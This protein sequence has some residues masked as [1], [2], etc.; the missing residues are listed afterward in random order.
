MK[1]KRSYLQPKLPTVFCDKDHI[2]HSW[3]QRKAMCGRKPSHLFESSLLY[4]VLSYDIHQLMCQKSLYNTQ[5][6]SIAWQNIEILEYGGP[7]QSALFLLDP[8]TLKTGFCKQ[9]AV[10]MCKE[11]GD[12]VYLYIV[13]A[14]FAHG[15]MTGLWHHECGEVVYF[16]NIL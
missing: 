15:I 3:N 16:F 14:W 8:P 7:Y 10:F 12:I 9:R 1:S 11:H 6:P 4:D 2:Y 13:L 5:S